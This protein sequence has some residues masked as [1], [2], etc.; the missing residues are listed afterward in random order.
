MITEQ[1]WNDDKHG[2][3]EETQ[4]FSSITLPIMNT[5]WSQLASILTL[6]GVKPASNHMSYMQQHSS[7]MQ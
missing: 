2:K 6:Q 3:T 4:K 5:T 7:K 1:W